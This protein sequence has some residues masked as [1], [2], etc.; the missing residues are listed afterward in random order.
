M[1]L[2][3]GIAGYNRGSL[4]ISAQYCRDRGCAGCVRCRPTTYREPRPP[5]WG[6]KARERAESYAVRVL[7]SGA[8]AG[9]APLSQEMLAALVQERARVGAAT[10]AK[11]AARAM[12]LGAGKY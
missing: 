8:K 3:M 10:A 6:D 7:A 4:V 12:S 5:G 9:L 2:I 11:A 1:W